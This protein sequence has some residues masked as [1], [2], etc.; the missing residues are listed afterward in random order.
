MIYP[1]DNA[2]HLLN[3]W[4]LEEQDLLHSYPPCIVLKNKMLFYPNKPI[5]PARFV[6]LLLE[7]C[8]IYTDLSK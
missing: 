5:R 6:S 8:D 7:E 2:I 3:N 4:D 1:V